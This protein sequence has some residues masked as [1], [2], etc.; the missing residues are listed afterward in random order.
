MDEEEEHDETYV[1]PVAVSAVPLELHVVYHAACEVVAANG[2][3]YTAFMSICN[4][5]VHGEA[6]VVVGNA[7]EYWP[8]DL[9]RGY[10]AAEFKHFFGATRDALLP[11]QWRLRVPLAGQ[12]A[13]PSGVYNG[14]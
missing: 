1:R 6:P 4:G 12:L 14:G 13:L 3:S 8:L 7:G 9:P 5:A 10:K 2:R 11:M